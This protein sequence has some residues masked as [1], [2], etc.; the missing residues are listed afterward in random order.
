MYQTVSPEECVSLIQSNQNV[1]IHSICATPQILSQ[2]L[3]DRAAELKNVNIYQLLTTGEA[4]YT[5]AKY[6]NSFQVQAFFTGGN[7]RQAVNEGRADYIPVFLSEIPEIFRRKIIP[8]DVAL[9]QV[10]PPDSHGYCTLGPSVDMS[11]AGLQMAQIKVAEINPQMPRSHGD[12]FIHI[13]AFD[14]VCAVDYPL[15]TFEPKAPTEADKAIGQHVASLVEDGATIQAGIGVIP[16]AALAA[17]K[18]H[19]NL[20]VH[21]EMFSDGLLPLVES[22]VVTGMHK[23]HH[24]GKIVSSFVMGTQ[25][26]YDFIDDNPAVRMMDVAYVNNTSIISQNPKVTAINSAIEVDLTGQVA[27]DSIGTRIYSGIGGQMDYIRGASLCEEGKPIIALPSVTSRGKSRITA[28]LN[29]GAGVVTTRAHVH[30]VITEYGI[31][32]IYAKSLRESAE[33]LIQIA[34]PD[35]REDLAKEARDFWGLKVRL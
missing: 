11:L 25:K 28:Q 15:P 31:A 17:L 8:L 2:C 21:T 6:E 1:F 33:A 7:T 35:H 22:G 19:K 30:Y 14:K 12:G 20:G 29:P 10:S 4:A 24:I 32:N 3:T 34:H 16:D 26:V 23:H 13:S 27:A 5:Q 9:V 18:D